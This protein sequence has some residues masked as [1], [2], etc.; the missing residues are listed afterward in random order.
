MFAP[1]LMRLPTWP[2]GREPDLLFVAAEHAD[3]IRP[4][5]LDGPADLAIEITSP[6]S[7]ARDY[8]DKFV[9][10]E[11]NGV[12][13]Y[14]LIDAIRREAW[15]YRRGEDGRYHPGPIDADGFY[16]SE[17]LPGFRLRAE[18]LWQR[19][20]PPIGEVFSAPFLMRLPTRPSGREPDLLF[21]ATE[22]LDRVQPIYLDGP[23]DLVV[24]VVSPES[25]E[26]DRG[27]KFV[28]YE[29]AGIPEYWLV[30]PLRQES[31]F[32]QRGADGHYHP[33]PIDADGIYWSAVLPGFWLRVGWLWQRPLPAIAAV[34]R[35]LEA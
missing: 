28:E 21:V 9:E 12:P 23:A 34:L 33:A 18:W 1:T 29:A 27:A 30:D 31:A 14:W 20:L 4:T 16:H 2:S 7:D 11:A 25:D 8:G 13:E 5:Y 19:P 22:H 3:R 15:F 10:Y 17:V 32:F 26:R 6:E 35:E 24:E